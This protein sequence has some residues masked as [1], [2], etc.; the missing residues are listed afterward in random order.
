MDTKQ[1]Y[2]RTGIQRAAS[3]LAEEMDKYKVLTI[4]ANYGPLLKK[5][6]E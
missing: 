2:K 3:D 5:L 6:P 4:F 1:T